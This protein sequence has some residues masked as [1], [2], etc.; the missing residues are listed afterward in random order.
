MPLAHPNKP[1]PSRPADP[2]RSS[3]WR[4]GTLGVVLAGL[5]ACIGSGCQSL[6][7]TNPLS[8]WKKGFD[9]SLSKGPTDAETGDTRNLM[10]KWLRPL[11]SPSGD[12]NGSTLVLGS[13]GWQPMKA[14]KNPEAEKELEAAL[15]LFQQ[16]KLVEAEAA[17][18]AIAKNRKETAYGMK[19]QYFLAETQYQ[20]KLY[21]KAHDSYDLLMKDYQGTE[22]VDKVVAREWELAQLWLAQSDPKVPDDKK[23]PLDARLDGR[24]PL[25]DVHGHGMRTLEH[26]RQHNPKGELA[27]DAVLRIADEHF[28]RGDYDSAAL[29][30]DQLIID[31]PKSP[32]LQ[33]AQFAVIDARMK[34]YVGPE[35]DGSGLQKARDMVKQTMDSFPDRQAGTEKLYHT[36]DLINDQDAERAYVRAAYYRRAGYPASAEYYFAEIP[37]R[38]PKSPW[39]TKAKTELASLAKVPRKIHDP[40]KIMSQPGSSDPMLGGQGGMGNAGGGMGGMGMGGMGMGGMGGMGGMN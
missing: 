13:N 33:R 32:F 8:L 21:V 4:S 11:P 20:Q 28:A 15:S 7:E 5:A 36:L 31:H 19:G 17:F 16:G 24:L 18:T 6:G 9:S 27:D 29:Y 12:P 39:A 40:S 37:Q 35:F 2:P 25:L 34:G 22:F 10:A 38:W 1:S 3:A 30:Y 26:V 23:L 14:E